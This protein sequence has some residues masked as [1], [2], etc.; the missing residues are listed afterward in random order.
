MKREYDI[1]VAL[2]G[3]AGDEIRK[4]HERQP[5]SCVNGK[6]KVRILGD[7]TPDRVGDELLAGSGKGGV[8]VQEGPSEI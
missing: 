4:L 7:E 6:S 5:V 8:R 2:M 1:D 3:E